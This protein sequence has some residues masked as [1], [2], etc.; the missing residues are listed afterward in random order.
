MKPI[1][2]RVLPHLAPAKHS[3]AG[4]VGASLMSGGLLVAQAFAVAALIAALFDG[5]SSVAPDRWQDAVT[6]GTWLAAITVLRALTAWAGDVLSS[7]AALAVGTTMRRRAVEAAL[8]LG[9]L[10]LSRRRTGDVALLTTR[11]IAAVEPYLTRY[12]PTL[13]VAMTLPPLTVVAIATQDWLSAFIVLLTLPLVPVFAIL[14]GLTTRDR[15]R[16]Q[17]RALE[18]LSGHFLDVVRGLPTLV[19]HRRAEA[20]VDTI[21]AVTHRY[22]RATVDTLKV[23]F[24][25][26]S[27]L[28]L[29]ATLSV[30]LVAVTVGL[31][32]ASGSVDFR[33]AL[34]VLLLA[35]EAY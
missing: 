21:R 20:Q 32:L 17:W 35:P 18:A 4:V 27:V 5:A 16:S 22:R 25:S 19:A 31:R 9:P 24:A 10:A 2:P 11:G 13:V 12:L 28:E 23:A 3:L 33:V 6:A 14:V 30:A 26:S 7:Q 29:V 8:E 15:A 1:D 34:I